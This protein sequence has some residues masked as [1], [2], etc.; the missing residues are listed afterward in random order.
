MRRQWKRSSG[1]S[2]LVLLLLLTAT[3]L[4]QGCGKEVSLAYDDSPEKVIVQVSSGGGL[5]PMSADGV[6][7]FRAWGD[8]RVVKDSGEGGGVLL[9]EG[10][11]GDGGMKGLLEEMADAGFFGLKDAYRDSKVMDGITVNV[12]ADLEDGRKSVDV[13]MEEVPAFGAALEVIDAYPVEDEHPY[14]PEKGYLV[15]AR[16]MEAPKSP[17]VP[18]P[19]I[20]ALVPGV[21]TLEPADTA[22]E[23]VA[24]PGEDFV[25][26]KEWEATQEYAGMDIQSGGTWFKVVPLYEPVRF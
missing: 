25:K 2:V 9:V 26:I 15:V 16:Q 14:V 3:F 18:P 10:K 24:I 12:T 20:A 19:E 1:I 22:N 8:G 23:P 7:T 13:Y 11:L 6:P 4:T 17:Q 5:A 21:Q